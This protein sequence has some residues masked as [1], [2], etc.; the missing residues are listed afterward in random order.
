MSNKKR[1]ISD[2]QRLLNT[3]SDTTTTSINPELLEFMDELTLKS[4]INDILT[5]QEHVN[6]DNREWLEQFKT[7]NNQ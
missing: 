7:D 2:I 6:S 3:Y 1:L 4:I 5:Q